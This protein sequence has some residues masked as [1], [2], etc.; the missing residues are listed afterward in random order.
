MSKY[1]ILKATK[2]KIL[3]RKVKT[4]RQQ[5]QLPANLYGKKIK[6]VSL[7]LNDK[8]FIKFYQEVGETNIVDLQVGPKFVSHFCLISHLQIHPVSDQIL[9]VDFH[10]VDLTEKIT[11]NIPIE[12]IG[13]AP[14]VKEH[15]GILVQSL[16]EIEI[17][18]LPVDLLDKITVDVSGLTEIGNSV[19][20]KDLSL[21]S[22]V[23]LKTDPK[24]VVVTIQA[25]EEE[26]EEEKPVEVEDE[27]GEPVEGEEAKEAGEP[28]EAEVE[29]PA[30]A[31][32]KVEDPAKGGAKAKEKEKTPP[33]KKPK[34]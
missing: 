32:A 5:G 34:K 15:D 12:L 8:K 23:T 24:A 10:Q 31:K 11:V 13:E 20:V 19:L 14:A 21:N 26:K 17:E 30:K 33:A 28:A 3:G 25:Q 7:T 4:L 16:S 9:H 22:K 29:D 6:S 1:P 18:A 27:D 2:R